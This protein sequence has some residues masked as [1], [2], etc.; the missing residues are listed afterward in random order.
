[1]KD[2]YEICGEKSVALIS[3]PGS[4]SPGVGSDFV[5]GVVLNDWAEVTGMGQAGHGTKHPATWTARKGH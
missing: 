1:M 4:E 5:V 3:T 2:Q